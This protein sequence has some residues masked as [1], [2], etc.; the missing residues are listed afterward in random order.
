MV[1]RCLWMIH[2]AI[3]GNNVC[4]IT[5][6]P[7]SSSLLT[8]DM[9]IGFMMGFCV[10]VCVCGGGGVTKQTDRIQGCQSSIKAA[11][12]DLFA[13]VCSLCTHVV[14]WGH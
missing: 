3:A 7:C 1:A 4:M 11:V 9:L 10:A 8:I 14:K 6:I 12:W 13:T 2:T 5:M